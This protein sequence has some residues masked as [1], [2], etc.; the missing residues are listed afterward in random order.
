MTRKKQISGML[1]TLTILTFIWS[2][3]T[4]LLNV[5]S[6]VT[7]PQMREKVKKGLSEAQ[8]SGK[9]GEEML[10]TIKEGVNVM[11]DNG[12]V[13]YTT[14]ILVSILCI[15]GALLMRKL[16]KSGFLI[17]VFGCVLS[18]IVPLYYVGIGLFGAGVILGSL[19]SVLFIIMYSVNLK[20][21]NK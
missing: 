5:V 4:L 12:E 18:V 3:I 19:I 7:L 20:E 6:L 2:G 15:I 1:N 9:N 11:L 17:Y 16:K 13:L 14:A 8:S 21:M 10:E